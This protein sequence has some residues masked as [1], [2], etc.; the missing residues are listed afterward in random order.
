MTPNYSCSQ[1]KKKTLTE[2]LPVK[3]LSLLVIVSPVIF[4]R[5][6]LFCRLA[7]ESVVCGM[8]LS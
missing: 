2:L 7:H 8:L 1:S 3:F 5:F 6:K 4:K